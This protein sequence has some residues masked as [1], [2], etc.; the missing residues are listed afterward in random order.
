MQHHSVNEKSFDERSSN[1]NALLGRKGS[2][3]LLLWLVV[4][5][6]PVFAGILRRDHVESLFRVPQTFPGEDPP[7]YFIRDDLLLGIFAAVG[8]L[9]SFILAAFA[10]KHG[11]EIS[12]MIQWMTLLWLGLY[13]APAVYIWLRC[14][15]LF[16]PNALI[17]WATFEDYITDP[18]RW[19]AVGSA[20]VLALVYSVVASRW[21]H[22]NETYRHA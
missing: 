15:N 8:A 11:R 7:L 2:L 9:L 1:L 19:L 17:P 6:G 5:F 3:I 16:E 18:L 14:D 21:L 22:Q 13:V 4:G 12:W 20:M 10:W